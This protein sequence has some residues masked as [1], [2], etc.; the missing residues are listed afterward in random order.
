M[1]NIGCTTLSVLTRCGYLLMMVR[2][3][4]L[5]NIGQYRRLWVRHK[6]AK[7]PVL[8]RHVQSFFALD[9]LRGRFRCNGRGEMVGKDES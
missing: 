5:C 9:V 1:W 8:L 4:I 7:A 3:Q 6:A 2:R